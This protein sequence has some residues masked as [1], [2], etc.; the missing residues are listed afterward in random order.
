MIE[1]ILKNKEWVLSGIGTLIIGLFL[2]RKTKQKQ[3]QEQ[4][5]H[6]DGTQKQSQEQEG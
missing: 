4:V 5:I 6:G 3:H 2:A 1:W